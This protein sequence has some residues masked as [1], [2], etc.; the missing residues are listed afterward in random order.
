MKIFKKLTCFL[1]AIVLSVVLV[2]CIP[3]KMTD[4][5]D[6]M[7]NCGYEV[8]KLTADDVSEMFYG[9][10]I[11]ATTAIVCQKAQDEEVLCVFW[12]EETEQAKDF[13]VLLK[14]SKSIWEEEIENLIEYE[15]NGKIVY[16]GTEGACEDLKK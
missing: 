9:L 14:L 5:Y 8:E 7:E 11:G 1:F 16:F 6:K 10:D 4:A 2:S 13:M 15:R 3:T 12:F